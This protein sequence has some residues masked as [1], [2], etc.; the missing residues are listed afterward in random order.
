[1][2]CALHF[3]DLDIATATCKTALHDM[4]QLAPRNISNADNPTFS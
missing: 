1:M 3:S 2:V 4:E